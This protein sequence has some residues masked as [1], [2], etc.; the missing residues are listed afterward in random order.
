M[1]GRPKGTGLDDVVTIAM[2]RGVMAA[3]PG[4]SVTTVIRTRFGE[5]CPSTIRRLRDKLKK[6]TPEA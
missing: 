2:V 1:R 4:M 6:E 5:E 3:N